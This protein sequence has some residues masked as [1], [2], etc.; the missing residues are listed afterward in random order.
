M[1]AWGVLFHIGRLNAELVASSV[2]P[3][4]F[5]R[6]KAELVL[7]VESLLSRCPV[8]VNKMYGLGVSDARMVILKSVL[9]F[10][11]EI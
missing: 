9:G 8:Q 11:V 6:L 7:V 4:A 2:S 10:C 5:F 3:R 1:T